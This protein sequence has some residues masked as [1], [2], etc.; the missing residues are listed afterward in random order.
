VIAKLIQTYQAIGDVKA[1][2]RELKGLYAV[3]AA[4]KDS[5]L[6]K[7]DKFCREQ[8]VVEGQKVLAFEIFDPQGERRKY[9]RFSVVDADGNEAEYISLGSYESTTAIARELGEIS[10]KQRAYHVDRYRG[11]EHL[12]YALV[13]DKPSYETVRTLVAEILRGKAR[14]ISGS[15]RPKAAQPAH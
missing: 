4:G 11:D 10:E 5:A 7:A 12:T 8:F 9:Y 6:A 3:R 13:Y 14:A 1:R 15:S 2:D